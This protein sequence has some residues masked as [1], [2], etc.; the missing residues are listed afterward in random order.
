VAAGGS[1]GGIGVIDAP[2]PA[3]LAL[4]FAVS[5]QFVPSGYMGDAAIVPASVTVVADATGCAAAPAAAQT[6]V[7]YHVTYNPPPIVAP[8][9]STWAG[10]Y[11]QWPINNWGMQPGKQV[12][13]GA[14]GISFWAA[15]A[16][17]GEVVTFKG[18]GLLSTDPVATPYSDSF[19][20]EKPV[21]LAKVW[22]RY[23]LPM[24]GVS[25]DRVL[26]GFAWVATAGSAATVSF[27]LDGVIWEK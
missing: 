7:C 12:K 23:T 8:A 15:G 3:P 4:P 10:V 22:T 26:G 2:A 20:V 18:G 16:A 25:Y 11:W 24:S 14:T 13:A 1:D 17:G 19:T 5:D 9:S 27:W 6:G 21:T